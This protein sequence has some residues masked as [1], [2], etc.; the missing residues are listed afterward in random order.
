MEDVKDQKASLAVED[1]LE[2]SKDKLADAEDE[3]KIWFANLRPRS[4]TSRINSKPQ[5]LPLPSSPLKK[6][7]LEKQFNEMSSTYE[8]EVKDKSEDQ[9]RNSK[10]KSRRRQTLTRN[11]RKRKTKLV[12]YKRNSTT[13]SLPRTTKS[14]STRN[15]MPPSTHSKLN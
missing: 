5:T 14:K 4:L 2:D 8:S 12:I 13:R 9:R 7:A 3:I 15:W 6:A 10:T 11:V 1:Q